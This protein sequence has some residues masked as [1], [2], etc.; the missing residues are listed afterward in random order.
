MIPLV[1]EWHELVFGT[2]KSL[3]SRFTSSDKMKV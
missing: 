1:A 3:F 2:A